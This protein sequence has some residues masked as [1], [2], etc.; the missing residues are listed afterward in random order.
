MAARL[1]TLGV[2]HYFLELPLDV[3]GFDWAYDGAGSQLARYAMDDF[4]D[5][6]CQR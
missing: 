5:R 4:M 1:E 2:P 3:H 6:V